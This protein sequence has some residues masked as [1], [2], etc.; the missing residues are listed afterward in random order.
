MIISGCG[1]LDHIVVSHVAGRKVCVSETRIDALGTTILNL[2]AAFI[3]CITSNTLHKV[4]SESLY[5]GV[6]ATHFLIT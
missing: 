4:V 3:V 6:K 5:P 2:K 1:G